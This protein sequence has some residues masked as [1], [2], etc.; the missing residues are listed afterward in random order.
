MLYSEVLNSMTR[1]DGVWTVRVPD[2]WKQGRTVFGGLQVA[3]ALRAM[4]ALVPA[5][6]PLR[7]LQIT[8]VA[9][10]GQDESLI[11]ARLL[12]TGKNAIHA[13]ARTMDGDQ[14]VSLVAAVFGARRESRVNVV[15][16]QPEVISSNPIDFLYRHG[17]TP[18]FTQ[19]FKL[20]WLVGSLPFSN[21]TSTRAVIEVGFTD[22]APAGEEHVLAMADSIPPVALSHLQTPVPGS[23]ITWTL[24]MLRDHVNDLRL[25]GWRLDVDMTAGRDGY[26]NQSVIVWGPGGEPVALS[27]QCMVIFG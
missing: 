2:D 13:E 27:R 10:P 6:L 16:L 8:F 21:D 20:R 14:T 11:H 4:R 17:F 12:R 1:R 22:S 26:T 3:L 24:E 18:S 25:S 5:T 19:H 15:P 23:S 7:V 9:P